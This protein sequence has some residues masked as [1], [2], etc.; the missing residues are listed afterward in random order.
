MSGTSHCFLRYEFLS[1]MESCECVGEPQGWLPYHAVVR[2]S[3]NDSVLGVM[4]LYIKYNSYGEFVFDHTWAEA[5]Q[6]IGRAYFPKLVSGV[7]YTPVTGSRI[8]METKDEQERKKISDFLLSSVLDHAEEQSFSSVHC[9]FPDTSSREVCEQH[10][11]MTRLGCQFHWQNNAYE[12]F[13]HY[14]SHFSSRKRKN[15]KKERCRSQ[16]LGVSIQILL[17]NQVEEDLWPIIYDFY[18]VTF[19][20]KGGI[21]TFTLAFFKEI[22]K[23][24]GD[25][26]LIVLASYDGRFVASAILYRDDTHLYGRH[27]GCFEKFHSLHFEVCYYQGL[28]YSIEHRLQ[29]FEPGAQ[30][31]Y[32]IT[33]GFL[34]QMTFSN[35]WIKDVDFRQAIQQ[36]IENEWQGMQRYIHLLN[37]KSPFKTFE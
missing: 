6:R 34:P 35:H 21:P 29:C 9:L 24:M 27:W 30:G 33:R 7:P 17:G 37:E 4:P 12:S 10:G 19:F 22:A 5:Y 18:R 28:E 26:L 8:L 14:L 16:D 25:Q 20:E 1:A 31:E 11:L 2:H 15:I 3:S 23:T 13:D 32:K 36:F